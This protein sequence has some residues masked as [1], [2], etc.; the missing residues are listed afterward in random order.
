MIDGPHNRQCVEMFRGNHTP[1]LRHG[2]PCVPDPV[3]ISC[4]FQ[5]GAAEHLK[6]AAG[7]A[8]Y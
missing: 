1:L 8:S 6:A 4:N 7:P 3:H 2:R 5:E